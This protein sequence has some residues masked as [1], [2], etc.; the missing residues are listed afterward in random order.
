V[1]S[2]AINLQGN[3][4]LVELNESYRVVSESD[5]QGGLDM[6]GN[7]TFRGNVFRYNYWH[8]I[9]AWRRPAEEPD[10]GQ[11]G[12]RLDDAVCGVLIYGNIFYRCSAGKLG[13]GGV[14]IHG[15]KDNLIDNNIFADCMAAVSLTPW[16]EDRWKQYIARPLASREIDQALYQ[17]RYPELRRLADDCD[18]N[19]V[20]R[21]LICGCGQVLRRDRGRTQLVDN[22]VTTDAAGFADAARGQFEQK[23][24]ATA[25]QQI[26]WRPIPFNEIGLYRD[27][28]RKELPEQAVRAARAMTQEKANG[29]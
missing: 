12:I 24:D 25:A 11:C 3:D 6:F 8:H 23:A 19:T 29:Q 4:H 13:F 2:S 26:G 1:R 27:R 22:L 21:N 10:C 18:I 17:A 14:Q 9:G 16:G 20:S 15:G 5:D 28:F 7:P